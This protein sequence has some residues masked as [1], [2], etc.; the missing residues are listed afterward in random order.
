M[1]MSGNEARNRNV[2]NADGRQLAKRRN[3]CNWDASIRQLLV[4]S[5]TESVRE[6]RTTSWA[7]RVG[8]NATYTFARRKYVHGA[9]NPLIENG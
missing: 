3:H 9:A 6:M 5:L 4:G 7:G 1:I 2:L 8:V